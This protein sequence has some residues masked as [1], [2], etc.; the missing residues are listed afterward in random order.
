MTS[1][2][3][4]SDAVPVQLF[5]GNLPSVETHNTLL[6]A[7]GDAVLFVTSTHSPTAGAVVM[8][9]LASSST[10]TRKSVALTTEAL[11]IVYPNNVE[12][13][14]I[15]GCWI[16]DGVYLLSLEDQQQIWRLTLN[17]SDT[18]TRLPSAKS[19]FSY[20]FVALGGAVLSRTLTGYSLTACMPGCT[21][22]TRDTTAYFAFGNA[23]L[24]YTRLLPCSDSNWSHVN[25]LA[26]Q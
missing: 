23:T 18:F 6:H 16:A 7:R 2:F 12:A 24:T 13:H 5:S 20:T 14:R 21:T 22:S 1:T 17:T 4:E 25:P 8:A 9:V 19:M 11:D 3:C 15:S 10:A 26:L